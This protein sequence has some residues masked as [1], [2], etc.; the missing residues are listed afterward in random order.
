MRTFANRLILAMLSTAG[1]LA[2][3]ELL[4]R[5]GGWYYNPVRV[6]IRGHAHDWRA[7][8][9]FGE[10]YFQWD[11]NLIWRPRPGMPPFNPHGFRGPVWKLRKPAGAY[12]ILAIGD[13]N[14]L[15]WKDSHAGSG[16]N[17][18]AY[19]Q[20]ELDDA[21]PDASVLNGGAWGYSSYQLLRRLREGLKF[22]PDLVVISPGGNDSHLVRVA[23]AEFAEIYPN[24][25]WRARLGQLALMTGDLFAQPPQA[26][27]LVPRVSVE[28]YR[29]HLETMIDECRLRGADVILLTRPYT[30]YNFDR[31]EPGHES[32]PEY[33]TP[34]AT[35]WTWRAA[36]YNAVTLDVAARHDVPSID[37]DARFKQRRQCFHDES[38]F[39]QRGHRA[40]AR[41]VAEQAEA[42]I[43]R[44]HP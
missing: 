26:A 40:L 18:P 10:E 9:A 1:T 8:H 4:L 24:A 22:E 17:W 12:R 6:E 32:E 29:G 15:G 31:E 44:K 41:L 16:P 5:A 13:S 38:H 39:N 25:L 19:L 42:M 27:E 21:H 14:T 28:D 34:P 7:Y 23:D 33:A 30:L 43:A 3:A 35:W 36:D 37:V 11:A 20:Q 2:A